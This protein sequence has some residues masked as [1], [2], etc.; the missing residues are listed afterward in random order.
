MN[1]QIK[2]LP[3]I[4]ALSVAGLMN[5]CSGANYFFTGA[6]PKGIQ[7]AGTIAAS[8]VFAFESSYIQNAAW[9]ATSSTGGKNVYYVELDK[10]LGY[11]TK[12]WSLKSAPS[13][14]SR[15]YVTEVGLFIA[16]TSGV[17]YRV[18]RDMPQ[19][20]AI[21]RVVDLTAEA[22][23]DT[24]V[25]V[26]S[27]KRNNTSYL[28]F[29][30]NKKL[31]PTVTDQGFGSA[32]PRVF[33]T[34]PIDAS[35]P[36][37]LDLAHRVDTAL[38]AGNWGYS[39][40]TDQKRLLFY[41]AFLGG[42]I[43]GVNLD[44][45]TLIDAGAAPNTSHVSTLTTLY[46]QPLPNT[47]SGNYAISGDAKGNILLGPSVYT[48]VND[49][50]SDM[51]LGSQSTDTLNIIDGKCF[52]SDPTCANKSLKV[53]TSAFGVIQPLSSLGDGR[54][55]GI[56][57]GNPSR[58]YLISVIDPRNISRGVTF[59]HVAD[60]PGDTYMYTDFTGSTLFPKVNDSLIVDLR[61]L[62]G[63]NTAMFLS[64]LS[65]NWHSSNGSDVAWQGLALTGR[66]FQGPTAPLGQAFETV[67]QV[68]N[69][70][71]V[72]T[73]DFASCKGRLVDHLELKLQALNNSLFSR[74]KT[75]EIGFAQ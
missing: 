60:I 50:V 13:G 42:A 49:Q 39:C 16:R 63:F 21:E 59:E 29:A 67:A 43:S 17:I 70:D 31:D 65:Y 48:Y 10:S 41:T 9:F 68:A 53:N 37:K 6:A 45:M 30:W 11:P 20:T 62:P 44:T 26:T 19:S 28:G 5:A 27:F 66:C 61:Q 57:R 32:H 25:C 46:K 4:F 52:Y 51:V 7:G 71:K 74:S 73:F 47:A 72:G 33:T 34:I 36:S 40:F 64:S 58:A 18:D 8:K 35:Q 1:Q 14:G 15:T 55:L 75:I 24:R 22:W 3:F 54:V 38:G 69:S 23:P 56:S 2:S 12:S